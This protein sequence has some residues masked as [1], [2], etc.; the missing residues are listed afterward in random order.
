MFAANSNQKSHEIFKNPEEKDV[1]IELSKK[2]FDNG[3][4]KNI[5]TP[6][7]IEKYID[8]P[9]IKNQK[10]PSTFIQK[11]EK[12]Q[13][14][15]LN[16]NDEDKQEQ[17][18][19]CIIDLMR[20]IFLKINFT[21]GLAFDLLKSWEEYEEVIFHTQEKYREHFIHQFQDFLLGCLFLDKL[22]QQ[23]LSQLQ[24]KRFFRRWVFAS[25]F[26]D[27]GYPA[28]TLSLMKNY[29]SKYYFNKIP[30]FGIEDIKMKMFDP[31]EE[32]LP[33]L[34]NNIALIHLFSENIS[35]EGAHNHD[36]TKYSLPLKEI[37]NLLW[38]ELNQTLDHG[39]AGAI[40]FLKTALVDLREIVADPNTSHLSTVAT[41]YEPYNH[42][43]DDIFISAAAIAGHNLRSYTYPGYTIDFSSRPIGSLLVLC[44]DL[45]EWDRRK[46]KIDRNN[47]ASVAERSWTKNSIYL[48]EI[49]SIYETN[50]SEEKS[51]TNEKLIITYAF[52]KK[53]PNTISTSDKQL[54]VNNFFNS[55]KTL[56]ILNLSDLKGCFY[57][58]ITIEFDTPA[59]KDKK[60][61]FKLER[62]YTSHRIGRYD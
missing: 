59:I 45:Q 16:D 24:G 37:E 11:I 58:E 33:R 17:I 60:L 52:R 14:D 5:L 25:L 19:K 35:L 41:E 54:I 61:I 47:P 23:Q 12:L 34:I 18:A 4:I 48:K 50:S 28:E 56:F 38:D 40:F 30:N 7:F 22:W 13:G 31:N 10:K 32:N 29:L 53:T 49:K 36:H 46:R 9:K 39:V 57:P 20:E 51:I 26:H 6:L 21:D 3:F 43:I 2:V 62:D 55:L 42:I 44:D 15:F 1:L 8:N 27:V